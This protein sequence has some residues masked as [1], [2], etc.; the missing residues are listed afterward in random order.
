MLRFAL[1]GQGQNS[2]VS[3]RWHAMAFA[4]HCGSYN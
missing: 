2:Q 1:H 4:V 3:T